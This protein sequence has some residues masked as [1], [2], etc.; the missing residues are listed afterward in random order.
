[1]KKKTLILFLFIASITLTT[2][3]KEDKWKLPT[4]VNF[5][6]DINRSAGAGGNL[7]FANGSIILADFTFDGNRDQADHVYFNKTYS[8][9]LTVSFDPN[10][11]VP[12]LDFDI[13]QGTYNKIRISFRTFGNVGDEH[14]AVE[15][16]YKNTSNSNTYPV[17]FEF[18]AE[19]FFD[20]VAKSSSGSSSIVLDKDVASIATIKLDP[21]YWFQT[22]STTML[23][24]ATLVN[25]SG[26]QTILINDANNEA[27]FDLV[28]DRVDEASEIFFD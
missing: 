13:P 11:P 18:E 26:T 2:C 4:D 9:G 17:R 6:M 10:N 27:I 15:G 16:T 21:I 19:E 14:I 25:V 7:S 28:M 5:K 22:I 3:K 23:D 24:N 12:A 20:V 8:G 1:M